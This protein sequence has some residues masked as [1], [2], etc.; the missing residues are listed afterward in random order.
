MINLNKYISR[1]FFLGIILFS[2]S[3]YAEVDNLDPYQ[4]E[5]ALLAEEE[6]LLSETNWEAPQALAKAT[7]SLKSN[8]KSDLVQKALPQETELKKENALEKDGLPSNEIL[9]QI[10]NK[11][12]K[13]RGENST[14]KDE[15]NL[16]KK[17]SAEIQNKNSRLE[18]QLAESERQVKLLSNKVI[19]LRNKLMVAETEVE[20]LSDIIQG[21]GKSIN[22]PLKQVYNR[23]SNR[24]RVNQVNQERESL[25]TPVQSR[26]TTE[27]MPIATVVVDKANLRAGPGMNHSPMMSIAKGTRLAIE[28]RSGDWFRVV[29]PTGER[30]WISKDI[31]A[32]GR[33]PRS[34]PSRTVQVRSAGSTV[35]EAAMDLIRQR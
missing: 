8:T 18:K 7:I 25:L 3:A 16:Q 32:F 31:V 33:D 29:A 35:E 19:E 9:N 5:A 28:T 34:V 14:L 23:S 6:K 4:A 22:P 17:S 15:V 2:N 27:E 26:K 20:R 21:S 1:G 11:I 10:N 24:N 12:K 30:A 13:L